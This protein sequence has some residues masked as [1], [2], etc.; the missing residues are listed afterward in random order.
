MAGSYFE[1]KGDQ[2]AKKNGQILH[3]GQ[4]LSVFLPYKRGLSPL[5][6]INSAAM[7]TAISSGVSELMSSPMGA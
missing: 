3:V 4:K 1:F 2:L 6:L 5:T 7:L